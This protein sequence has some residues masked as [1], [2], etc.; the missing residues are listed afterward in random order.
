ML[1]DPAL[2]Q[3]LRQD[4]E[5]LH[6]FAVLKLKELL[7]EQTLFNFGISQIGPQD[8]YGLLASG[9]CVYSIFGFSTNHLVIWIAEMD[10]NL[11]KNWSR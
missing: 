5:T 11:L 1:K 10:L 2:D 3:G 8:A 9:A 7:S 4:L 6:D